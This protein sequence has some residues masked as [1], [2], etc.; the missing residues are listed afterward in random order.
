MSPT[1]LILVAILPSQR[2]LEIARVLGWYRIPYAKAPKTV[3]VDRLAFYQTARFG[4]EKWSI[5]YTAPVLGHELVTRAELL[6]TEPG[7]PRA[8]E[9]YFKLQ[10][11]PLEALDRPVPSLKWRRITF[12]YT[13]G[14]RLLQ[15]TEINDLIVDGE[16]RQMLWTALKDRGLPAEPAYEPRRG[17][18]LDFA[19]LCALGNLGIVIDNP[20]DEPGRKVKDRGSWQYLVVPQE[21]VRGDAAAV[22]AEVAA[23]VKRLGGPA[24]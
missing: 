7:H 18:Q 13:T 8:A 22:A 11:G 14:E 6:R 3:A 19:I 1:E 12:L 10:L 24:R 9:Q 17:M 16:E 15:A 20:N 23:A 5:R 21:T 2:D 4:E